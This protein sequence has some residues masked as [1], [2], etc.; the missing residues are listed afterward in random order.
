MRAAAST[1]AVAGA[2]LVA[3]VFADPPSLSPAD[4]PIGELLEWTAINSQNCAYPGCYRPE[5]V[6]DCSEGCAVAAGTT[7]ALAVH[8]GVFAMKQVR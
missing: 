3:V 5:V 6:S 2:L 1:I 4:W 8:A 7:N